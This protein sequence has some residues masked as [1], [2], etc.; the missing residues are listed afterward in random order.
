METLQEFLDRTPNTMTEL[1]SQRLIASHTKTHIL[2]LER[3]FRNLDKALYSTSMK[4]ITVTELFAAITYAKSIL[5]DGQQE[6]N[7]LTQTQESY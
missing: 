3:S 4:N 5:C 2:Q 1:V 6:N 7:T